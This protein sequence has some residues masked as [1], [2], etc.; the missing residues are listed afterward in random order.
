[1]AEVFKAKISAAHGFEKVV[2]IKRILPNLAADKNFVSMFI[3]EAKLTAQ[4][5][6]PKIVQVIDFG[7]VKGQYFI[8]LEFID[9]FDALALLRS[10][11]SKQIKLPLPIAM[12]INMEVLDALDY[13][14]NA[15]DTEGR[16]MRLVHRDISPSNVFIA[17]RGDVKLG[18]FGIAHAQKRESKTQAGTLKGK[19]GYMS[20]E[21]VMGNVLDARSDLFAVGIVLAE[22][23]MGRRLFTAPNDL[24]V[25]LMVRDGRLDRLDKYARDL[26]P[27]LDTLVRKALAKRVEDRFQNAAEFRD[28]MGDL[29][30][31]WGKRVTPQDVGRLAAD[32]LDKS[33]DAA[34]KMADQLRR[35]QV[36]SSAGSGDAAG[37]FPSGRTPAPVNVGSGPNRPPSVAMPAPGGLGAGSSAPKN[38]PGGVGWQ[39]P[40][41]IGAGPHGTMPVGQ[42]LPEESMDVEME[43]GDLPGAA[44][45]SNI[46]AHMAALDNIMSQ[47]LA[48]VDLDKYEQPARPPTGGGSQGGPDSAAELGQMTPMR[49]FTELSAGQ[50]TGLLR[51]ELPGQV[52]DIYLVRGAPESV[53]GNTGGANLGDYLVSRGLLRIEELQAVHAQLGRF[54]GRVPDALAGLGLMRQPDVF[55]LQA[56]HV[57]E[58][59]LGIFPHTEGRASFFRGLRNPLESF[60]LALD[61]FEIVGA[62]VL[63]LPLE[64]LQ[65]RFRPLL[66]LRPVAYEPPPI[67]PESF[68]LGPTPRDLLNMLDGSR[69]LRVW[70]GS[71]ASPDERVTFLRTLYLLIEAGLAGIG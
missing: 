23:I 29:L 56:E 49:I 60:S 55:R 15:S 36:G 22:M 24:D 18:D 34:G 57:R 7:E 2:V 25:L 67:P 48:I 44:G 5:I 16:P 26:P 37:S 64:Y 17:R 31:R 71:F 63:T 6:H 27:E 65:R 8:A 66:D 10:A 30:F 32:L 51:L 50:E 4:L 3:D 12:F 52:R 45:R 20:P 19:Y 33:P 35:W 28:A 54:G 46:D 21:Q 58:Q 1:M 47:P 42:H 9:G 62:G 39:R 59:V 43:D 53:T 68:R 69:T 38:S 11:A 41:S 40:P 61:P 13:A 70:L 14:H